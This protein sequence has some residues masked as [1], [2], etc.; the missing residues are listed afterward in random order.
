MVP[1]NSIINVADFDSIED[2]VE[3]VK[4]NLLA[5]S[6]IIL[7]CSGFP[8]PRKNICNIISGDSRRIRRS[9]LG[10]CGCDHLCFLPIF[11]TEDHRFIPLRWAEKESRLTTACRICEYYST[12]WRSFQHHSNRLKRLVWTKEGCH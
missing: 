8:S 5:S 12:H 1:P 3:H 7:L 2:V 11:L 6:I 4:V 9:I 10:T